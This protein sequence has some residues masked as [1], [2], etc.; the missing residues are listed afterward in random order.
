MTT[1]VRSAQDGASRSAGDP[2]RGAARFV[3]IT[4]GFAAIALCLGDR[5]GRTADAACVLARPL[6]GRHRDR[7]SMA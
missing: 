3:G 2:L 5:V 4:L 6:A 7:A 1:S